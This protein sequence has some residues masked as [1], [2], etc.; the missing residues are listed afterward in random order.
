VEYITLAVTKK[1]IRQVAAAGPSQRQISI[2][3]ASPT[4]RAM[5]K[6][7]KKNNRLSI[8]VNGVFTLSVGDTGA[9]WRVHQTKQFQA[10]DFDSFYGLLSR[11]LGR[12]VRFMWEDE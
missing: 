11:R 10:Q 7:A 5:I 8:A 12:P 1:A 6:A 4:L 9:I 3:G 2:K